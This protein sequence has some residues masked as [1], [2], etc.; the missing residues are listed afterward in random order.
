MYQQY[1]PFD[2]FGVAI[3]G[4]AIDL[5]A[6]K[7]DAWD[8]DWQGLLCVYVSFAVDETG[9]A[10]VSGVSAERPSGNL[11]LKGKWWYDELDVF[12]VP[13]KKGGEIADAINKGR[14]LADIRVFKGRGV[15]KGLEFTNENTYETDE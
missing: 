10:S 9:I 12:Y 6:R 4:M 2:L 14:I 13:E 3:I 7:L 11:Y 1:L 5:A 8:L 15:I